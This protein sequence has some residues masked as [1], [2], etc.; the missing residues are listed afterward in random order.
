MPHPGGSGLAEGA[1]LGALI[2]IFVVCAFVLHNYVNLN[3]GLNLALVQ[4]AAYF[5]QWT[6]VGIVIGLNL[7]TPRYT[8]IVN[9]PALLE[10]QGWVATL[11]TQLR[12]LCANPRFA[13]SGA[14]SFA[15]NAEGG[16]AVLV[17]PATRKA[18]A[19]RHGSVNYERIITQSEAAIASNSAC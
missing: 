8:I 4:A 15:R 18:C 13:G 1:R 6:I 10:G 3:I 2:G 7:Q 5:V 17:M 16:S 19:T 9:F 12:P 14:R 11:P